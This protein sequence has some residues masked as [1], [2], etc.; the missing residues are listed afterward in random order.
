MSKIHSLYVVVR[1]ENIDKFGVVGYQFDN[2]KL[3]IKPSD[4]PNPYTTSVNG[5]CMALESQLFS[6][7]YGGD[8]IIWVQT[9]FICTAIKH[10]YKQ[11]DL[12]DWVSQKPSRLQLP[13]IVKHI[14]T[15]RDTANLNEILFASYNMYS[16]TII[17]G[18]TC[19]PETLW[20]IKKSVNKFYDSN[21]ELGV[22]EYA[23]DFDVTDT[24]W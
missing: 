10:A 19:R 2:H 15:L 9:E 21:S 13:E 20:N 22:N 14:E 4:T 23:D 11:T 24:T 6:D 3:I 18:I 5:I 17:Q 16:S 7:F 1:R 12:M 8:L